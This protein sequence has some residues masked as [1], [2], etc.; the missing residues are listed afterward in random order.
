MVPSDEI[1]SN[2]SVPGEFNRGMREVSG[3][4]SFDL[5]EM[6]VHLPAQRKFLETPVG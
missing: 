6:V 2:C 5:C 1:F 3:D 4:F